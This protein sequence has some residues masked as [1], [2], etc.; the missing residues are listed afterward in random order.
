MVENQ[1]ALVTGAGKRIGK[2]I[3]LGLA[4]EGYVIGLHYFRTPIEEIKEIENEIKSY[5]SECHSF[6]ADLSMPERIKEMFN[7]FSS[8]AYPF[9]VLINSAG[10]MQ[11]GNLLE[12]TPGDW[13]M[14]LNINLRAPWLCSKFAVRMMEKEGGCIIN[15]SDSGAGKTWVNYPD[16]SISK[17]GLETLTRISAKT[18]APQIRV[19]AIAPGLILP[20]EDVSETV[21][22]GLIERLP[23]KQSGNVE[24]IINAVLFIIQSDYLTGEILPVDGGYRL[25]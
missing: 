15:I 9:T 16:Y 7:Y 24:D 21:W 8:V 14:T 13:D 5:G 1:F 4:R 2:E 22:N 19:N 23:L 20:S 10:I 25:I 12:R 11:R 6:Q 3:A 18:F 17:A